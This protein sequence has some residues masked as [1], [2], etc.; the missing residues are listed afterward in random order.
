MYYM[1]KHKDEQLQ[2][3][4]ACKSIRYFS[5]VKDRYHGYIFRKPVKMMKI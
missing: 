2:L 5:D 1:Q 4:R 3:E